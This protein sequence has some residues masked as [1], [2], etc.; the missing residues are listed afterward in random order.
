MKKLFAASLLSISLCVSQAGG[1]WAS[2]QTHFPPPMTSEGADV[3]AQSALVE[4]V[5]ASLI[6]AIIMKYFLSDI[7]NLAIRQ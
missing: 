1:A 4:G 6:A 3:G 2:T 7:L 5:I